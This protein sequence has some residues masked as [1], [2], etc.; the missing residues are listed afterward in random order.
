MSRTMLFGVL[1]MPP[2]AWSNDALDQQQR[3][4][5]YFYAAEVI[6]GQDKA[7]EDM[8]KQQKILQNL[9]AEYACQTGAG[10]NDP[11]VIEALCFIAIFHEFT[12]SV[13]S[14]FP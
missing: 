7:L 13:P 14:L 8:A 2:S 1:K 5:R 10:A 11:R 12:F 6:E 4:A 3:H 9:L